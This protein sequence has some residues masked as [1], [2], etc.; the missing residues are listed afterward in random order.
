MWC[1][2][3]YLTIDE[4]MQVM[5]FDTYDLLVGATNRPKPQDPEDELLAHDGTLW[6]DGQELEAYHNWLLVSLIE[7]CREN[8]RACLGSGNLIRLGSFSFAWSV[9]HK[10]GMMS[11]PALDAIFSRWRGGPFPDDYFLRLDLAGMEFMHLERSGLALRIST[12]K[13]LVAPIAGA[14]LCIKETDL[15]APPERLRLWL[16]ENAWSGAASDTQE[17]PVAA[18]SGEAIVKAFKEGGFRTKGEA[19]RM[20]GQD[21]KH[22]AWLALWKEAVGI[23]PSLAKPGPRFGNS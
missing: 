13:E 3:G 18:P 19:H 12:S 14:P 5:D 10:H 6:P 23:E 9:S 2:D 20:F 16:V 17:D 11:G 8:I 4:L 7:A 22:L 21:M 15:P 1:P